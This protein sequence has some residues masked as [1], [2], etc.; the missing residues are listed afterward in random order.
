MRPVLIV[1]GVAHKVRSIEFN[2][3]GVPEGV[4]YFENGKYKHAVDVQNKFNLTGSVVMDLSKALIW[5]DRYQPI[6]EALD[7]V[8]KDECD[9]LKELAI[10]HIESDNPFE[11]DY[12]K[13]Y[14]QLQQKVFGLIDAQ[15][16]VTE[17]ML[18]DVDPFRW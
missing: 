6:Y 1:E 17:F 12:R 10:N 15:E 7:K 18:E 14:K 13:E 3:E 9:E 2:N 11:L 5:N 8:I 4:S 16:L